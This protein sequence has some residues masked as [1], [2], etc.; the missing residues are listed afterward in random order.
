MLRSGRAII[1]AVLVAIAGLTSAAQGK[2]VFRNMAW[3]MGPG[4][5][6]KKAQVVEKRGHVVWYTRSDE[7][8][9]IGDLRAEKIQ[10]GFIN[11]K[12][13]RITILRSGAEESAFLSLVQQYGI[14]N[15][16]PAWLLPR[17]VTEAYE[18]TIE[19]RD[20]RVSMIRTGGWFSEEIITLE[21]L[22][23][24]EPEPKP[25]QVKPLW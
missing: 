2:P 24:K 13:A 21:S 18:W 14:P 1:A 15:E 25:S 3:G 10:Y 20:L 23:I 5:L 17:E 16:I 8:L 9:R 22:S 4:V 11:G 7:D 12:L 19:E 6:G